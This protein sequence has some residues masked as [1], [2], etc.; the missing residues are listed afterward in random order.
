MTLQSRSI[1]S[2]MWTWHEALVP[3]VIEEIRKIKALGSKIKGPE[4]TERAVYGPFLQY[5][6][7][8]KL[9]AITIITCLQ[10]LTRHGM[11]HQI[12]A[13][14]LVS[15]VGHAIEDESS[16]EVIK[17]HNKS[18]MN[19]GVSPKD[20]SKRLKRLLRNHRAGS[21]ANQKPP[22]PK[23]E[24]KSLGNTTDLSE[25]SAAITAKVGATLV[26]MLLRVAKIETPIV[27]QGS[28][29]SLEQQP[30]LMKT[31]QYLKGS[32]VGMIQLHD[33]MAEKLRKEPVGS[34]IVKHLPMLVE[35][36]P[37]KDFRDGGFLRQPVSVVRLITLYTHTREY[38]KTAAGSGDLDKVFAALDI[39]GRTPWR[40]NRPVFDV[41]IQ[42]W[43]TG[44]ALAKIPPANPTFE[45]PAEPAS[46]EDLVAQ[47]QH[48]YQVKRINNIRIGIHSNRCFQNFQLEVARAFLNETF[49]FP[50]NMDFRG[51]AYP[52]PP[53]LNHM[54]ADHCRGL[55]MFGKG[56]ELG[57]KGSN[58]FESI[59]PMFTDTTRRVS[60]S[61]ETLLRSTWPRFTI[62]LSTLWV[63]KGGG[64]KPK[65][66]GNALQLA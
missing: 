58:G 26:A 8:Q 4:A 59:L 44:E 6:P 46:K 52:I 14:R 34:A 16:A 10:Q 37:W 3:L 22:S 24:Q 51:R 32:R 62:P 61:V 56:R 11:T 28:E 21:S 66:L 38:V 60:L 63:A 48:A 2:L 30:A 65:I 43:N 35:P 1:G 29:R 57:E 17:A 19:K 7:P 41:M 47:K 55:L 27:K 12:S 64:S 20:R 40:I 36:R 25:W 42:A 39:L 18:W 53:Y 23:T 45:Y 49:Y 5:I 13:A 54:G 9:S 31:L 15:A 50:H 33:A